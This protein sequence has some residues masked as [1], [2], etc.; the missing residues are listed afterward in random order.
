M[1]LKRH[2]P[3]NL[4]NSMAEDNKEKGKAAMRCVQLAVITAAIVPWVLPQV[5]ETRFFSCTKS[6]C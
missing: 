2:T 4:T 3:L 1:P 6:Y 5:V